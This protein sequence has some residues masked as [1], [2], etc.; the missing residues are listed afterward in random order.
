LSEELERFFQQLAIASHLLEDLQK[1]VLIIS[2]D[3]QD[4]V[5]KLFC[6]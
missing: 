4:F 6:L 2:L 1:T 3:G 5:G